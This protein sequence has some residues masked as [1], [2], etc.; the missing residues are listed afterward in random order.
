M[1]ILIY[2]IILLVNL[3]N[4]IVLLLFC[5]RKTTKRSGGSGNTSG[6]S[7]TEEISVGYYLCGEP[8]PYKTTIPQSRVTLGLLKQ[9]ISKRGNFR[10]IYL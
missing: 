3:I 5:R 7:K 10:Y 9:H 2:T 6:S 1:F 8:I 4:L